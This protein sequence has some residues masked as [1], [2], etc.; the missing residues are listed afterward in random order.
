VPTRGVGY[1]THSLSAVS[2]KGTPRLEDKKKTRSSTAGGRIKEGG[3]EAS[4]RRREAGGTFP[5][6]ECREFDRPIKA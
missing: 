4:V 2:E 5:F 6:K 3:R 1:R